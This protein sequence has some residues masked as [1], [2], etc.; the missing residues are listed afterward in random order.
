M[1]AAPEQPS[2]GNSSPP[3]SP[4]PRS[5]SERRLLVDEVAQHVDRQGEDDGGVF[6]RRDGAQRLK[7]AQLQTEMWAS[8][9][10]RVGM[11]IHYLL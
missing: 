10:D 9:M 5:R 2:G 7:V 1:A 4:G 6:L 11:A 8:V 3:D